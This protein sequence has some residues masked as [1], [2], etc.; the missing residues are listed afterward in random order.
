[1]K[2]INRGSSSSSSDKEHNIEIKQRSPIYISDSANYSAD[3]EELVIDHLDQIIASAE[4][5]NGP[6]S[7]IITDPSM[8]NLNLTFDDLTPIQ[9]KSSSASNAKRNAADHCWTPMQDLSTSDESEDAI[10][11]TDDGVISGDTGSDEV[12]REEDE[13]DDN[14]KMRDI[15]PLNAKTYVFGAKQNTLDIKDIKGRVPASDKNIIKR[16]VS[17]STCSSNNGSSGNGPSH[18]YHQSNIKGRSSSADVDATRFTLQ[19]QIQTI[20]HH[21]L[22]NNG[23]K[24]IYS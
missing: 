8:Y 16:K 10:D 15:K 18:P 21:K 23:V 19:N 17:S 12:I 5:A 20:L 22:T 11:D 3:E 7:Y 1:M 4:Q 2:M 14:D 24:K 13:D 9:E 6:E